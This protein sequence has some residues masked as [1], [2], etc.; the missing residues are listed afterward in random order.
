MPFCPTVTSL[1][2]AVEIVELLVGARAVGQWNL[3]PVP[4][5]SKFAAPSTVALIDTSPATS[6]S[7][8]RGISAG[9]I[10]FF[11]DRPKNNADI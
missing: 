9:T 1:F 6:A 3:K 4:S 5:I 2:A 8:G 10:G 11:R 7:K